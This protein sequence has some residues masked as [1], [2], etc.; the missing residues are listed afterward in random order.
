MNRCRYV[1]S[2]GLIFLS[3]AAAQAQIRITEW[4]YAGANGEFVELTNMGGSPVDMRDN[5]YYSDS[6]RGVTDLD[7]HYFGLVLAGGVGNYYRERRKWPFVQLG[8]SILP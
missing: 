8:H 2:L 4:M 3:A 1:A 6:D 5:W 7:I